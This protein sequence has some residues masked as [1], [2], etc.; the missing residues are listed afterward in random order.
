MDKSKVVPDASMKEYGNACYPDRKQKTAWKS[1]H[2]APLARQDARELE[3]EES[4]Q[5]LLL[6][7]LSAAVLAWLSSLE[8]FTLPQLARVEEGGA[9]L[10]VPT[11]AQFIVPFPTLHFPHLAPASF[12]YLES[13]FHGV[14]NLREGTKTQRKTPTVQVLEV[15]LDGREGNRVD[16][17]VKY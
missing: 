17:M 1:I 11:Q 15:I 6:P 8:G 5:G 2:L 14:F 3:L 4:A 7:R 10:P 16:S 12:H 9:T 13:S